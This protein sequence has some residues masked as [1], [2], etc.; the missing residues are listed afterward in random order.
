MDDKEKQM[1]KVEEKILQGAAYDTIQR[2]GS[3]VKEH[4]S[5]YYGFDA[6]SGTE[7]V[8]NLKQISEYKTSKEYYDTNI[9]QQAGFSAEV[10]VSA[11]ENAKHAING[12]SHKTKR[13]DDLSKQEYSKSR[14]IGGVN[15]QLFDLVETDANGMIIEGTARQL[16]FVGSNPEQC[17]KRLLSSKFDKYRN[18]D[19]PIE[20]PK[21]FYEGVKKTLETKEKNLEAEIKYQQSIGNAD[22]AAKNTKE[23]ERVRKTKENLRQSNITNKEAIEARL[24]PKISTAKD[25]LKNANQAGLK[26]AATG[27]VIGGGISAVKNVVRCLRGETTASESAAAIFKD[28]GKAAAFSYLIA[29]SGSVIKG[30][31]QNSSHTYIRGL[32]KTNLASGLVSATTTVGDSA[33]KLISGEINISTFADQIMECAIGEIGAAMFTAVSVKSIGTAAGAVAK[34]AAGTA[35]S[36]VG[37]LAAIAIYKEVKK[38]V[39]EYMLASEQRKIIEKECEELAE[40]VCTYR[41]EME[42]D[43]ETYLS[44]HLSVFNDGFSAMDTAII[45][46]D[47][48]G[49][50][51]ANVKIQ[52]LLGYKIQFTSQEEFD[53]LMLSDEIFQL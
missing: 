26:Q 9:K 40:M 49:F 21:D 39:D 30:V 28:T 31:M 20:V 8:K 11:R 7:T 13:T 5:A 27:A 17:A 33:A 51:M 14:E 38:S 34:I 46:N 24:H 3:A 4:F 22:M 48:D 2:Y 16:K 35:G 12:T 6:E 47:S 19:V 41:K 23:L 53:D 50:V 37:Y 1:H 25:I 36:T 44:E 29:F 45:D 43:V 10:K 52:K 32:A 42:K 18:A 15:D